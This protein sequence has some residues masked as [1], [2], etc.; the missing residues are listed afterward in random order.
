MQVDTLPS[1]DPV[2]VAR[3]AGTPRSSLWLD[4][5]RMVG[6]PCGLGV[7]IVTPLHGIECGLR[8]EPVHWAAASL[9]MLLAAC[10]SVV[11]WF[12]YRWSQRILLTSAIVCGAVLL[13]SLFSSEFCEA[14][15]SFL[16]ILLIV[17]CAA[18]VVAWWNRSAGTSSIPDGDAIV[19][20]GVH[21]ASDPAAASH[22]DA[23]GQIESTVE[24]PTWRRYAVAL[25][26]LSGFLVYMVIVPTVGLIL[27]SFQ[28]PTDFRHELTDMTFTEQMRL[29]SVSGIVML[30][31]LAAGASVGSFLNVVI[32]RLPRGRALL[33]PPSACPN[34]GN[35][36]SS[37]D[38]VPILGW[39]SLGGRCRECAIKIS[40]RYPVMEAIVAAIFVLFFYVE[41]LSG[42]ANLPVRPPNLYNG[43][44]WILLYTKWDLLSIYGFHM[45]VLSI[46]LAWG[47]INFDRF[48]VP[49]FAWV[50]V[51]GLAIGI[52]GLFPHLNPLIAKGGQSLVPIPANLLVPLA[53]A[54]V[55]AACGYGIDRLFRLEL[56]GGTALV[57]AE[58]GRPVSLVADE[59]VEPSDDRVEH[60]ES[61]G[62]V[63][64]PSVESC[65][66]KAGSAPKPELYAEPALE[67]AR[68]GNTLAS[69][70]LVGAVFGSITALW[71]AL[72]TVMVTMVVRLSQR[73]LSRL[74]VLGIQVCLPASLAVFWV[75]TGVLVF[76]GPLYRLSNRLF[77]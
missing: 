68:I 38:N 56:H 61:F 58:E 45:V 42:G 30:M 69:V 57:A 33:W 12:A 66:L 60:A 39:L 9:L 27:E 2:S 22:M 32:Y 55:G 72:A 17:S 62:D 7:L 13:G 5:V 49:Q 4:Y 8:D 74:G 15:Q 71:V 31:F 11:L 43:I 19:G 37:R 28:K 53:G 77:D 50:F 70:A 10:L 18:A 16:A 75:M 65:D 52:V 14:H 36:I 46:L 44:V 59:P 51:L 67:P 26:I 40:A 25:L 54:V 47:M 35:R 73:S 63:S 29:H 1:H 76:W 3:Q 20:A 21:A 34:C 64:E 41:L 48:R 24:L 6:I 23:K